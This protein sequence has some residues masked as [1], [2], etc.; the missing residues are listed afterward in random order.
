MLE[1]M[2]YNPINKVLALFME[3]VWF[4]PKMSL[5]KIFFNFDFQLSKILKVI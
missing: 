3:R 1:L 4:Q 2:H 5:N